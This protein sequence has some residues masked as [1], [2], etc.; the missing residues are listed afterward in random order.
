AADGVLFKDLVNFF[1]FVAGAFDDLALFAKTFRCIVLG[2]SASGKI[3]S[4]AHSDGAGSD[5]SEARKDDNV[6]GR[7]GSGEA[8][9]ESK[10]DRETVGE[11]NNSIADDCARFEVIFQVRRVVAGLRRVWR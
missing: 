2:I 5:L 9:G 1:F 10:R 6:R 3:A 11:A 7:D 8:G 4:K